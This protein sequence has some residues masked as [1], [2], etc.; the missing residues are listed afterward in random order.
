MIKF[1]VCFRRKDSEPAKAAG[2]VIAQ[3]A[4]I[5]ERKVEMRVMRWET[6]GWI[7]DKNAGHTEMHEKNTVI[8]Q[9]EQQKLAAPSGP[10]NSSPNETGKERMRIL[11]R[12]KVG[13]FWASRCLGNC[14]THDQGM[15][16]S[17]NGFDFR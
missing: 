7:Q 16:C 9:E 3:N 11:L 15:K 2:I 14:G 4:T 13:E 5:I 12:Y 8:I 1:V 6:N 10:H 17:S